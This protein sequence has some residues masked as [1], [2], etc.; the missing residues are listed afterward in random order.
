MKNNEFMQQLQAE[1]NAVGL[2]SIMK[3]YVENL[4]HTIPHLVIKLQQLLESQNTKPEFKKL[5]E[6]FLN[7]DCFD[8]PSIRSL[9][10][11]F[12]EIKDTGLD[13]RNTIRFAQE[14]NKVAGW[15]FEASD[16]FSLIKSHS[17]HL[18][19]VMSGKET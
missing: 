18:Q 9:M 3:P 14:I 5:L 7:R 8:P 15:M 17:Y 4:Q 11:N 1:I 19:Q 2:S 6:D 10:L 13:E 12:Y 16:T